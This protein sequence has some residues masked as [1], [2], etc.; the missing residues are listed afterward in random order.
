[1]IRIEQIRHQKRAF[2]LVSVTIRTISSRSSPHHPGADRSNEAA[3]DRRPSAWRDLEALAIWVPARPRGDLA[4]GF[5]F[6]RLLSSR[7]SLL[8]FNISW[9]VYVIRAPA[10]PD[11]Q[12]LQDVGSTGGDTN[13]PADQQET[14]VSGVLERELEGIASAHIE[15]LSA[16]LPGFA[17]AMA[18]P[19]G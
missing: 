15:E 13:D 14:T 19:A 3:V 1:M 16:A 17:E 7:W 12:G 6:P 18:W 10:L 11:A 8:I 4:A 2:D 5:S 9:P